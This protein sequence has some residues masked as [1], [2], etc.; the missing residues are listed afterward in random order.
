MSFT[1]RDVVPWG[2]SI[3]EYSAMFALS[4]EDLRARILDCGGGPSSFTST[5]CRSGGHAV[6]ADPLYAFGAAEIRGRIDEARGEIVK[7]MRA[8]MDDYIWD[9]RIPSLEVLVGLR[10]A[11]MG[12]FLAD[13]DEGRAQGRYV[14]ASLPALPFDDG[15]F[16]LALC[17]H[18]LFLYSERH[19]LEFHVA[20]MRELC[21]VAEEVRVFPVM[22]LGG[23]R[24]R[25]LDRVI[26]ELS[27]AGLAASVESVP[28]EF[29]KGA[30]EMLRVVRQRPRAYS[31]INT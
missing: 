14:A 19:P 29:R 7:E 26:S 23:G 11:A 21:R 10:M 16:G 13:Y 5:L 24:S 30:S 25:H 15:A 28:Y 18:F 4:P 6:S 27:A 20:S 8:N 2:R 17:S 1:L 9:S 3:S 22:E 12:E 31:T